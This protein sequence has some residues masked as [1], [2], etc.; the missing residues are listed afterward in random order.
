MNVK[1]TFKSAI[2]CSPKI[3]SAA[4]LLFIYCAG[5][6]AQ[7]CWHSTLNSTATNWSAGVPGYIGAN[8]MTAVHNT[9]SVASTGYFQFDGISGQNYTFS[10]AAG[11]GWTT[12]AI[13]YWEDNGSTWQL[14][15]WSSTGSL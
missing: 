2:S 11:G 6:Y 5:T 14:K 10:V 7:P 4:L 9:A 15:N 3:L 1:S 8:N 13:D 12:P